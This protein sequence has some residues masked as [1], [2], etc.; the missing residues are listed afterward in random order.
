MFAFSWLATFASNDHK[1]CVVAAFALLLSSQ[2]QVQAMEKLKILPIGDS[3]TVGYTDNPQWKVPF[4]HGYRGYLYDLLTKHGYEPQ[5]LGDSP[6]PFD[7]RW[8]TPTNSPV[9]DLAAIGQNGHCAYGGREVTYVNDHIE[10]WLRR[11]QPDVVLLMIGTNNIYP[12]T[13]HEQLATTE[14]QLLE[15]AEKTSRVSRDTH[16]IV[17]Q[18]VPKAEYSP[19]IVSYNRFIRE[20]VVPTMKRRGAHISTV[21]QYHNFLINRDDLT[22][23]D[24]ARFSNQINHPDAV[25]YERIA[26]TWFAE[27]EALR[28]HAGRGS[29]ESTAIEK[30]EWGNY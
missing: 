8:G 7:G 5:F 9:P 27:I 13:T 17:A 22:T 10:E 26:Q 24:P 23:I 19:L 15:V 4:H 11:Y 18:I 3:I 29:R 1:G 30:D 25:G 2:I 6:E 20:V 12:S 21:D 16:L 28:N 14:Q